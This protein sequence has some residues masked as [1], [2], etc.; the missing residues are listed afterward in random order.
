MKNVLE[1]A[2]LRVTGPFHGNTTISYIWTCIHEQ[3]V[4]S[5]TI[6]AVYSLHAYRWITRAPEHLDG[7]GKSPYSDD[8]DI[9]AKDYALLF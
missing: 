5:L 6:P 2:L 4:A 1:K 8:T 3:V 7:S 9:R